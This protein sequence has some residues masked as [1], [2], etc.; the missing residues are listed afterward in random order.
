MPSTQRL[1]RA[2]FA[3]LVLL[4]AVPWSRVSGAPC[5]GVGGEMAEI[6]GDEL[7]KETPPK[8]SP[9]TKWEPLARLL[10]CEVGNL[11]DQQFKEF[12]DPK[13]NFK[14]NKLELP[15]IPEPDCSPPNFSKESCLQGVSS[16]LQVHGAY[17]HFVEREYP[18][19]GKVSDIKFRTKRL[20]DHVMELMK[21]SKRTHELDS[22]AREK[23]VSALP[24]STP[25]ER[26]MTVHVLLREF[27]TFLEDADAVLNPS[28]PDRPWSSAPIGGGVW[29]SAPGGGRRVSRLGSAMKHRWWCACGFDHSLT[30]VLEVCMRVRPQFDRS[31]GA[32]TMQL[33][34]LHLPPRQSP[35]LVALPARADSG[36]TGNRTP[37]SVA[38]VERCNHWTTR[39]AKGDQRT[40]Q[41]VTSLVCEI[42]ALPRLA[43]RKLGKSVTSSQETPLSS[44]GGVARG[45]LRGQELCVAFDLYPVLFKACYLQEQPELLRHLVATWPLSR[46]D[47]QGLLGRTA[48]CPEDL[49]SRTCRRCLEALLTGLRDYSCPCGVTL[50]RWGRTELLTRMCGDALLATQGREVPPADPDADPDA[51]PF[52][53]PDPCV[54]VRLNAFV[55]GRNVEAV[56]QVLLL[57][58]VA[59]LRLCCAGFR[60]DSLALRQ[61]FRALKL[62]H[63]AGLERLE[64]VHNVALE[65]PHLELLLAELEFPRLRSLT[66]PTRALDVRR[67]PPHNAGLLR[68]IGERLS[69]LTEL[70][71]LY[72]GFSTL[73]GHLRQILSPL[74]T[75]LQVLELANCD[76]SAVD[77]AYLANSLHSEYLQSLDLSGHHLADLFPLTFQKLLR[78]CAETLQSLCLEECALGEPQPDFLLGALSPCRALRELKILGNPLG[79]AELR[80]LFSALAALPHLR[81]VE[82][83]VPR[84]CYPPDA[85]YPLDE[86][87]LGRYDRDGFER[88]RAELL[89]IL[90]GAGRGDV[91]VCT[92]LFGAFDPDIHETSNEL[93]VAMLHSFRDALGSYMDTVGLQIFHIL[94]GRDDSTLDL[95]NCGVRQYHE[96]WRPAPSRR[97]RRAEPPAAPGGRRLTWGR[98]TWGRLTWGRLTWG[99]LTWGLRPR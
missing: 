94:Q 96:R 21:H 37:V 17:L 78:R 69:H 67:L 40:G 30:A 48:D 27:R 26:K 56:T 2:L 6:S 95:T 14:D 18:S 4:L 38:S 65:A 47:L 59:P 36:G 66:L 97:R 1:S 32:L 64:L 73:T 5:S 42:A 55:T 7:P 87:A 63:T 89:A 25:W 29:L 85:S 61:L 68:S 10:I 84:D 34:V 35:P 71:Q 58:R 44:T 49:T 83:P 90:Q 46:L 70:T 86:A 75:P 99:R 88:A 76:L 72:L 50:G 20:A 16:G 41:E 93:G 19:L 54:D 9:L 52:P 15:S 57:R 74:L 53:T 31:A 28:L 23:L 3:P 43:E 8:S 11:R 77:M 39:E 62:A 82:M 45:G 60:G 24:Q 92:P 80:R 12:G 81:Y 79:V 98:L 91:E 22:Q 33:K 13:A 51:D